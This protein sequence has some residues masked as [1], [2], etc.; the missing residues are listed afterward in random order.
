MDQ[1]I[2]ESSKQQLF[3]QRYLNSPLQETVSI[4]STNLGVALRV[5]ANQ[6][7]TPTTSTAPGCSKLLLVNTLIYNS[8]LSIWN[9]ELLTARG[10]MSKFSTV[11][12]CTALFLSRRAASCHGGG[13]TVVED[14]SWCCSIR[15]V[16]SGCLD[17]LLITKLHITVRGI[18]T[19][20]PKPFLNKNVQMNFSWCKSNIL[21]QYASLRRFSRLFKSYL[22]IPSNKLFSCAFSQ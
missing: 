20:L 5:Q 15:T 19:F 2:H 16:S 18:N 3:V 4:I 6:A 9:T 12:H 14:S 21:K 22:R 10:I 17:F 1:K 8:I 13:C 11:T 7:V